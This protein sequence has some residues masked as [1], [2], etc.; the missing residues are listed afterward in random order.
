[1]KT[2]VIWS[3]LRQLLCILAL[4][5]APHLADAAQ[6]I[7]VSANPS[8]I[9]IGS[10]YSGIGL[11]VQGTAPAGSDVILRFTGAPSELHLREKG[12]VF[13]LLWMNVG[14]VSVDN[15]PG[16]CII[17]SSDSFGKLGSVATPFSLAGLIKDVSV[18]QSAAAEGIDIGKELLMLKKDEHLYSESENGV[19]LGPDEDGSRTFS[20]VLPVP[21]ALAPGKYLVEAIAVR[22]GAVVAKTSTAIAARMVG[23]PDW[24][25]KMAFDRSLLYG[26]LATVIALVSGLVIG[27]VFQH[28]GAH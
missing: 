7:T 5:V 18:E 3:M 21:S 2:T 11:K 20:A 25:S 19:R 9:L 23:F 15:V 1:M 4:V 24:L 26:I 16:V 27:L 10:R 12:K 17:D 13:G 22:D 14:T 28:R 6:P 8:D